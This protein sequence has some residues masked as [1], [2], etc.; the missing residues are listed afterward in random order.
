ML[1]SEH[2]QSIDKW[3]Q[4]LNESGGGVTIKKLC[5]KLK[6]EYNISIAHDTM[7]SI[8]RKLGYVWTAAEKCGKMRYASDK[9][10]RVRLYLTKYSDALKKQKDGTHKIVYMDETFVH[11]RHSANFTW[12]HPTH[13]SKKKVRIGSGKGKRFIIVHAI[14]DD[15]LLCNPDDTRL[16]DTHELKSPKKSSEWV[17]EGPV[18][19]ADYHKNMNG[20]NFMKWCQYRLLPSF[21]DAYPDKKM[22]LVLDNAP[23]H[24]VRDENYIDP[25]S[26]NRKQLIET[27]QTKFSQKK[28]KVKRSGRNKIFELA[29]ALEFGRGGKNSPT[30]SELKTELKKHL[31]IHTEYQKSRLKSLFEE[32]GYEL[33]FTPPYTPC[34]QPIEMVWAY[35]KNRVASKFKLGRTISETREHIMDGFYGD[36]TPDYPG[37]KP[38]VCASFI[39]HCHKECQKFIDLD[40]L[41]NGTLYRLQ[42]KTENSEIAII[43][44]END[45]NEASFDNTDTFFGDHDTDSSDT[46]DDE[47]WITE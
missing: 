22:I 17:F 41:L 23:Y 42:T 11:Q 2:I 47:A 12:T 13:R 38:S 33:I 19:K 8:V 10:E 35:I 5:K 6:C 45:I 7:N 36:N 31:S 30:V 20:D 16:K 14:S 39:E 21:E 40:P 46:S 18:K 27:L 32:K 9:T 15:G 24:H 29:K 44:A 43:E 37:L 28:I 4:E 34:L 3:V 1:S 25:N 26:L